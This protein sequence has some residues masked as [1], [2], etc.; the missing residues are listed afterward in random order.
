MLKFN[1][2][3]TF[4]NF[5]NS[6]SGAD[7]AAVCNEAALHAARESKKVVDGADLYYAID[8]MIGGPEKRD[9][10]MSPTE[11]KIV[12]YHEAGHA[13]AGWLLEHTDALLKV[14]IVPRTNMSLGFAQYTPLDLKLLS[15]EQL[16]D[17]MCMSLGGRVAESLVF[18]SITQGAQ[19]DLEKVTKIA[20]AQVQ[21]YGMS[22]TVGLLSFNPQD[23][24]Q[25]LQNLDFGFLLFY[26]IS[27]KV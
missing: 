6:I 13:L 4:L 25:V 24:S 10:A 18:N 27:S 16:F 20:Y 14:S 5:N 8:R 23:T 15:K 19:N 1:F 12:A 21:Q 26:W 11:K 7:I 22:E 2:H 3:Y 17:R 9:N